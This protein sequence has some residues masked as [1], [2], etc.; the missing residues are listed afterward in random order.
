MDIE[1]SRGSRVQGELWVVLVGGCAGVEPRFSSCAYWAND[2]LL[3]GFIPQ[4]ARRYFLKWVKER[5]VSSLPIILMPK[6]LWS[7]GYW[8]V[9][10]L[11]LSNKYQ[12]KQKSKWHKTNSL[13]DWMKLCSSGIRCLTKQVCGLDLIQTEFKCLSCEVTGMLIDWFQVWNKTL[14]HLSFTKHRLL[15][16]YSLCNMSLA[17]F[18]PFYNN[19]L[20][21]KYK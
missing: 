8:R 4:L 3:L 16:V 14:H 9:Y 6:T 20:F 19:Q 11:E 13:W 21:H 18:L 7:R 15:T 17:S 5:P 1:Q 12:K 10:R 2:S